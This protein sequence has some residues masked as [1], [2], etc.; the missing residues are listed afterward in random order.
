MHHNAPYQTCARNPLWG[1]GLRPRALELER[2]PLCVEGR[3]RGDAPGLHCA[4]KKFRA[5]EFLASKGGAGDR[6]PLEFPAA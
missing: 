5:L 3:Q 6:G 4:G 2:V 1:K